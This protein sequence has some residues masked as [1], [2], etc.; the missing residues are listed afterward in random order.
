MYEY[1]RGHDFPKNLSKYGLI[2]H[3][4]GCMTN[5]REILSRVYLANSQGIPITNYG[6]VIAYCKGVL[7]R[8]VSILN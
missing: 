3:C 1:V 4:G 7:S 5:K 8:S 2:I 6:V